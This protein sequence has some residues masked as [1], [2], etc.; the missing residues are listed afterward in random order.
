MKVMFKNKLAQFNET[1]KYKI[2]SISHILKT[3]NSVIFYKDN[4]RFIY[5]I[6]EKVLYKY[7]VDNNMTILIPDE[8]IMR[9]I[10]SYSVRL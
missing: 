6:T 2:T 1:Y 10:T 7:H 3:N 8:I 4:N 5:D 9:N